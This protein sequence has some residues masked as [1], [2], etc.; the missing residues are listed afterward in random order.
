MNQGNAPGASRSRNDERV[1]AL[2]LLDCSHLDRKPAQQLSPGRGDRGPPAQ[3]ETIS[4]GQ[5]RFV[6]VVVE[7]RHP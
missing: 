4:I 3:S 2:R 6:T 5:A 7:S 1:S